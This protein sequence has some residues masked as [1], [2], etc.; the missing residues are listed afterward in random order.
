MKHKLILSCVMLSVMLVAVPVRVL[1]ADKQDAHVAYVLKNLSLKKDVAAK[2]RP[3]LVQ[4]YQEIARV[5]APRK[6]LKEKHQKAEDA[7]KLTAQQCDELFQS[8]QKQEAGELEVRTRYYAKFKTVLTTPQAYQAI[9]L[10][11][12]KLK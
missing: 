7:G 8:K 3:L 10:C 1:G 11:N 2:F 5:K 4:Y 6:A 12:D 9:K